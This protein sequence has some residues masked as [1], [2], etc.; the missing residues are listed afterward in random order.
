MHQVAVLFRKSL[1]S[2]KQ[3]SLVSRIAVFFTKGL[4]MNGM[5]NMSLSCSSQLWPLSSACNAKGSETIQMDPKLNTFLKISRKHA[6]KRLFVHNVHPLYPK[7]QS[8][9]VQC[10][11]L[12]LYSQ[13][14]NCVQLYL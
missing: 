10:I 14:A 1:K 9:S 11:L 12:M 7:D 2:V 5:S 8:K 3:G 4:R 13:P 6:G